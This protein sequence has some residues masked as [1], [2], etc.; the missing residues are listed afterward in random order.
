MDILKEIVK[1]ILDWL[2]P[3]GLASAAILVVGVWLYYDLVERKPLGPQEI[4]G[5]IIGA[6]VVTILVRLVGTTF[7]SRKGGRD[8]S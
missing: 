6:L 1:K 5:L 3:V 7:K 8:G 2:G 4:A